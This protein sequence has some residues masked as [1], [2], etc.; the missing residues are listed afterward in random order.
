[1]AAPPHDEDAGM[2]VCGPLLTRWPAP[3]GAPLADSLP[4]IHARWQYTLPCP[5]ARMLT[6]Q[7]IAFELERFSP[8]A[9]DLCNIACPDT[10]ARSVRK[11]QAEY[12]F[13][14]L[15][16]CESLRQQAW[17]P[18]DGIP[19]IAIGRSRAPVWPAQ[20]IGSIS[21]TSRLAAAAV[22]AADAWRGIGIDL[23]HI[24]DAGTHQ[25]LLNTVVD[26]SERLLLQSIC[27]STGC[28]LDVL[29]TLVFSAK[30]SLFKASFAKVGR[31]FDFSSARVVALSLRD[32]W[33]RLQ[34][35]EHLCP[36]LPVGQQCEI[37]FGFVDPQTIMTYRVW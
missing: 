7:V 25:A 13:G 15:A 35:C 29:L 28:A 21:H 31:Y 34:L 30:E 33:V 20:S 4:S 5:D 6:V 1:M 2:Q 14:R 36:E 11:R 27:R 24:V 3:S 12:F 19:Q 37:G 23:E 16:A 8:D 9:F 17:L 26:H 18:A 32:G 10:I 22:A